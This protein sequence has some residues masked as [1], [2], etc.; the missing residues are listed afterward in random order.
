MINRNYLRR[1]TKEDLIDLFLRTSAEWHEMRDK[2]K[3]SLKELEQ[4]KKKLETLAAEVQRLKGELAISVAKEGAHVAMLD[5]KEKSHKKEAAK[6]EKKKEEM[7]LNSVRDGLTIH[8]EKHE[9]IKLIGKV[10]FL[11]DTIR[12]INYL[13]ER[14]R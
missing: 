7:R 1:H 3:D 9:I 11:E 13:R 6:R 2:N 8:D 14:V 4:E 12:S 10:K 5:E